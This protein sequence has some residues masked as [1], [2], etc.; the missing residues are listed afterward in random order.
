M[1]KDTNHNLHEHLKSCKL[2]IAFNGEDWL[3]HE[4][5][6]HQTENQKT[7][8]FK[9]V[10]YKNDAKKQIVLAF[11][12]L[13]S[14]FKDLFSDE[15]ALSNQVNG[16]L[17]NQIVPQLTSCFRAAQAANQIAIEARYNLSFTGYLNG[18]WLA[19]YAIY[20]THRYLE[21]SKSKLKAVLFDSPGIIKSLDEIESNVISSQH[22]YKIHELADC[23][24]CYLSSPNLANSCNLHIGNTYRIFNSYDYKNH[25]KQ[26]VFEEN[27]S[28]YVDK[29]VDK[30]KKLS[31]FG[32]GLK[33]TI[34]NSKFLVRGLFLMFNQDMIESFVEEFDPVT[35]KP[36][37][38]EVVKN[39]PVVE[40]ELSKDYDGNLKKLVSTK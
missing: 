2:K 24:T 17:L 31:K 15:G 34:K 16:V 20:F 21:G 19:E 27:L 38:F 9:A 36:R 1:C 10:I 28:R 30:I 5:I 12:G 22:K 32:K 4:V 14:D 25:E 7:C 29:V 11:K 18:A 6:A 39:W 13:S 26:R 37:Y 8:A 3:V 40:M 23:I 35:G 33:E